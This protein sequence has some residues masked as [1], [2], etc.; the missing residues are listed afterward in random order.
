[1]KNKQPMSDAAIAA[2]RAYNRKWAAEHKEQRAAS[3]AAYWERV[4]EKAGSCRQ[5][6]EDTGSME[7]IQA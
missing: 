2:R 7:V 5:K 6:T 4:A 1:M 3:R